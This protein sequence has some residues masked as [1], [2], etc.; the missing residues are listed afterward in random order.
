MEV[1]CRARHRPSRQDKSSKCQSQKPTAESDADPETDVKCH[2]LI[3]LVN[4]SYNMQGALT[5]QP[6]NYTI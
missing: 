2:D 3:V 4:K 1:L 5:I 6:P